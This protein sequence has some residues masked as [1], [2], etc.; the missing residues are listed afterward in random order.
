MRGIALAAS[1]GGLSACGALGGGPRESATIFSPDPRVQPDPAWPAVTWQLAL[2]PPSAARVIDSFRIAVRPTPG[3]YQVYKGASWAKTPTDMLQDTVLRAL[4]DSGR[5]GAVARQGSGVAADYK[6]VTDLRRFDADYAGNALPAATI[7]VNVKLLHTIDQSIVASR[8]FLQATPAA[9]TD[10]A[11]VSDAFST[12]L[13]R[14]GG[15][16]S[17]WILVTGQ[18]HEARGHGAGAGQSP[19]GARP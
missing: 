14:I 4:E 2:A 5:I 1:L 3:E 19:R 7:E 8:T 10:V 9:G 13:G 16:I 18:E 11:R 15:E 6:L 17:G 12:S